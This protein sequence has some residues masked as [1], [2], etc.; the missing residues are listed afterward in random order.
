MEWWRWLD[1]RI[2]TALNG[3]AGSFPR[4]DRLVVMLESNEFVKTGLLVGLLWYAWFGD[5]ASSDSEPETGRTVTRE[6]V[7]RTFLAVCLATV[8]ARAGEMFLPQRLRPIHD[9]SV[10]A[11]LAIGMDPQ[12]HAEWSSFPSDHAVLLCALSAGLWGISRMYGL[13]AFA[14]SVLFV[15]AVRLYTGLH[16]PSDI[17]GGGLIGLAIMWFV[18]WEHR[19]TPFLVNRALVL[20]RTRPTIFYT[21]AFLVT[22]QVGVFFGDIRHVLSVLAKVVR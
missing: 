1:L 7:L 6:R 5:P 9:P 16:Y 2:L 14:W 19:V 12:S 15:F 4:F 17:L 22:W 18:T 21:G 11:H 8:A 13:F 3:W 10:Q 20:E